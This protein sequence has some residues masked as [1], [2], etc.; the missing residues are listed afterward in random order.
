MSTQ[1]IGEALPGV[2]IAPLPE[3][4]LL[5]VDCIVLA[6]AMDADGSTGWYFRFTDTIGPAEALGALTMAADVLR[7][8]LTD[9]FGANQ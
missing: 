2:M 9:T 8:D 4:D 3:T 1:P 7:R 6:K 5:P